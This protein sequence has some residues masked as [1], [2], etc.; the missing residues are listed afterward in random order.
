[1]IEVLIYLICFKNN[2][3]LNKI[4]RSNIYLCKLK[5]KTMD[6]FL[7]VALAIVSFAFSCNSSKNTTETIEAQKPIVNNTTQSVV[8]AK[9]AQ[10]VDETN[11]TEDMVETVEKKIEKVKQTTQ[12]NTTTNNQ[13][14]METS[15]E[16]NTTTTTTNPLIGEYIW[17]KTI[18]CGRLRN[19]TTPESK[20]EVVK[21]EFKTNGKMVKT[22]N[23]ARAAEIDYTYMTTGTIY[24]DRPQL[25]IEGR[26][27]DALVRYE[28]GL[29]VLDYQYMDLQLEYYK[30]VD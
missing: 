1:M 24:P 9:Q 13:N 26:R 10:D 18:C 11:Q 23:N 21:L 25:K 7:I 6:K 16:T 8:E 15:T 14:N 17:V 20:N 3:K 12:P 2:F 22:T 28:D 5:F 19:V 27:Q 29:L 30:K 4:I